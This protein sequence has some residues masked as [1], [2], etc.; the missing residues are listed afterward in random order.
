MYGPLLNGNSLG[1]KIKPMREPE[2]SMWKSNTIK[3]KFQSLIFWAN[4]TIYYI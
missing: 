2:K 1:R 3:T 4:E